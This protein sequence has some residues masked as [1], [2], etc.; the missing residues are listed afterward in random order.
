MHNIFNDVL[1]YNAICYCINQQDSINVL[2]KCY[3]RQLFI[4]VE[5]LRFN[6]S[7]YTPLEMFGLG[8]GDNVSY[9][10]KLI[11]IFLSPPL[12]HS[13]LHLSP[14]NVVFH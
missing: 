6:S 2:I 4:F 5:Q 7:F 13:Y 1:L 12:P 14:Y 3:F 11:C 10:F 8:L 9:R